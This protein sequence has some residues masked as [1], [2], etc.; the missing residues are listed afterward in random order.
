MGVFTRLLYGLEGLVGPKNWEFSYSKKKKKNS[1]PRWLYDIYLFNWAS[2]RGSLNMTI[3]CGGRDGLPCNHFIKC[4]A[5][6]FCSGGEHSIIIVGLESGC[7]VFQRKMWNACI[8]QQLAIFLK[9]K[10]SSILALIIFLV[11]KILTRTSVG[12]PLNWS[13]MRDSLHLSNKRAGLSYILS[14]LFILTSSC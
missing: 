6:L 2:G 7:K 3:F 1:T 8:F 11:S 12:Q 10:R 5:W 13:H 9:S 4:A 14:V